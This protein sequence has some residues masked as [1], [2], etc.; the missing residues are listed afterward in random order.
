MSP[1]FRVIPVIDI[2]NG[3]AV[4]ASKGKRKQYKPVKSAIADG[5]AAIN[6]LNA[7]VAEFGFNE[8]Y[9]ADLDAIVNEKPNFDLIRQILTETDIGLILDAGVRNLFDIVELK[10]LGVHKVILA[11]ETIDSLDVISD[12]IAELDSTSIVVS[13]DMKDKVIL[14]RNK[15]IRNYNIID[16]IDFCV[17]QEVKEFILLDLIKVGTRSGC[18]DPLYGSIRRKFPNIQLLLGGGIQDL[19]DLTNLKSKKIDGALIAT[20]LHNG[21]ITSEML[22][23]L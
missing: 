2:M 18:Y 16:L 12:A 19:K 6:L 5:S 13:I 20:A 22:K 1:N 7:Y 15:Q 4:H 21:V 9:I 10:E 3:Q 11:T 23:K 8:V 14:A 17:K